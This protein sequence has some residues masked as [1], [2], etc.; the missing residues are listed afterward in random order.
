MPTN[1]QASFGTIATAFAQALSDV[2]D[3]LYQTKNRSGQDP[4][5]YPIRLN[6]KIGAL[7]G[8]VAGADGRPTAQS[9]AV[10]TELSQ[11]LDREIA[12]LKRVMDT[13]LPRVNAEITAAGL[14]KIEPKAEEAA[15]PAGPIA[16]DEL[17][18]G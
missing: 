15:A 3:S 12:R 17:G 1:R 11:Q 7:M 4:L 8:V 14:P 18:S 9:Y 13:M 5:N 6:N 16:D 2:E 10:F